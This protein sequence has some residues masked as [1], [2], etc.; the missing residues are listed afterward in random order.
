MRFEMQL[1]RRT[2][3]HSCFVVLPKPA[4]DKLSCPGYGTC[5]TFLGENE[6]CQEHD[7][8]IDSECTLVGAEVR[9]VG[10]EVNVGSI[11][12]GHIESPFAKFKLYS[13]SFA[14]PEDCRADGSCGR[15]FE[16][17]LSNDGIN[18]RCLEEECQVCFSSCLPCTLMP[19]CP[20]YRNITFPCSIL[21]AFSYH[22]IWKYVLER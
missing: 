18:G 17:F 4:Q 6:K 15:C 2:D 9:V 21:T 19:A 16:C 11:L 22:V 3:I 8:C 20:L 5:T 7:D 12:G 1:S 13:Y 10:V 14:H